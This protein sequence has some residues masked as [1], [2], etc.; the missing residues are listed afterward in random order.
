MDKLIQNNTTE[1]KTVMGNQDYSA[2]IWE[3]GNTMRCL[4]LL[5]RRIDNYVQTTDDEGFKHAD[6]ADFVQRVLQNEAISLF[7]LLEWDMMN[8]ESGKQ[9]PTEVERYELFKTA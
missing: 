5:L 7:R 4:S 3:A 6:I 2:E 8:V 9:S 1:V